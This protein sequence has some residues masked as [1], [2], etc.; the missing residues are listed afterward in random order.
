ML[1]I[2]YTS[3]LS[4]HLCL[5]SSSLELDAT[6]RSLMGGYTYRAGLLTLCCRESIIR[7]A[8]SPCPPS[9]L[10]PTSLCNLTSLIES[11]A[12]S[13]NRPPRRTISSRPPGMQARRSL[14][15]GAISARVVSISARAALLAARGSLGGGDAPHMPPLHARHAGRAHCAS[16]PCVGRQLYLCACRAGVCM[17][18]R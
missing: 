4:S 10:H 5:L 13:A 9:P 11:G 6:H 2:P 3:L 12:E 7:L 14:G 18:A 1:P 17:R 16:R 8:V 15:E